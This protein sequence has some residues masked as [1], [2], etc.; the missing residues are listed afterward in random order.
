MNLTL[1]FIGI[2]VVAITVFDFYIIAKKGKE[3]SISAHLIRLSHKHPSIPF[4]IGFVCGHLF[5]RMSDIS[6]YGH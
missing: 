3:E 2:L 6:V 1:M 4:L 5:W